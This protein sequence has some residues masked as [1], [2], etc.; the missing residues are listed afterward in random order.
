MHF[1]NELYVSQS[2]DLQEGPSIQ[3]MPSEQIRNQLMNMSQ[4]L[5]QAQHIFYGHENKAKLGELSLTI[6]SVYRQTCEKHHAE[7]LKRK[8]FIEKQK[9]FYE[10]LTNERERV[11]NEEKRLKQEEKDLKMNKFARC[12]IMQ[13]HSLIHSVAYVLARSKQHIGPRRGRSCR[14]LST[15]VRRREARARTGQ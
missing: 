3:N 9:E 15:D 12:D 11:K 8:Q 1:G 7:L 5:Q 4:A 6:A 10:N 13:V 14:R 2:D